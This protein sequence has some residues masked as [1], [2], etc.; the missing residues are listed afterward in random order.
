MKIYIGKH[1]NFFGPFQIAEKLLFWLDRDDDRVF[2]LGEFLAGGEKTSWLTRVCQWIHDH[3]SRSIYIKIDPYDTWNVDDTLSMIVAPMLR[4]LKNT[5]HSCARV[6]D[7]D[8]PENLKST[9]APPIKYE[10]D[11][12]DN[13]EARWDYVLDEMIWA[14]ENHD[15]RIDS[16]RQFFDHS[17]VD[18]SDDLAQQINQIKYDRAGHEAWNSRKQNGFR[19]F[20]KYFTSL[21]S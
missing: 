11:I 13:W 5:K 2:R 21:W 20:G 16:E 19:L 17:D 8:V 6:D 4:Q 12:D 14:F 9:S 1:I 10:W 15:S 18:D 3:R 7:D